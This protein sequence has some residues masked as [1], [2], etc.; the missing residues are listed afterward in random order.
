MPG[1]PEIA[2]LG[3]NMPEVR[4][5]QNV[6]IIITPGEPI[7]FQSETTLYAP[8]PGNGTNPR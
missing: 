6:S 3:L 2:A 8:G 4:S 5:G 1:D 7:E